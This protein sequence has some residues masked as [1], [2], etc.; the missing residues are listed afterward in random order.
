MSQITLLVISTVAFA[1]LTLAPGNADSSG[2]QFPGQRQGGGTH[3][4]V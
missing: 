2:D 4:T 3:W 1:L